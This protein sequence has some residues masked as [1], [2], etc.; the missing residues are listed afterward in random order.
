MFVAILTLKYKSKNTTKQKYWGPVS[1][2]EG[3]AIKNK[4][5]KKINSLPTLPESAEWAMMAND[6]R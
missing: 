1:V 5:V 4:W 6:A 3:R 2:Q